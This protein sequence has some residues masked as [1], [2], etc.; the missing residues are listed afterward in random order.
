MMAILE[1]AAEREPVQCEGQARTHG[2]DGQ[3]GEVHG[4]RDRGRRGAAAAAASDSAKVGEVRLCY[5]LWGGGDR[6][7]HLA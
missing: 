6:E 7:G 3:A 2:W 1:G 4:A 5:G